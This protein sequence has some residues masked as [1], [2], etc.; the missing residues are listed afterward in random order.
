MPYRFSP[1]YAV[2]GW[3]SGSGESIPQAIRPDDG[4]W[5]KEFQ[6]ADWYTRAGEIGDWGLAFWEDPQNP[7]VQFRRGDF[8]DLKDFNLENDEAIQA[9][10]RVYQYWIALSDCDG[11][12]VDAVKLATKFRTTR[13]PLRWASAK[14]VCKSSS[15]PKRGSTVP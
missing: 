12:R 7:D 8:Y 13:I 14:S 10:A 3:R 5:P 11:F 15:V 9:L 4:V 6:N 1:P 2:H